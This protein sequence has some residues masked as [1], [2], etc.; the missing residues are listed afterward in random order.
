[1][2][3]KAFTSDLRVVAPQRL[4]SITTSRPMLEKVDAKDDTS[5]QK[6]QVAKLDYDDYDDYEEPKTAGQKISFYTV[7]FF[8]LSLLAAGV[9]CIF[10]TGRELFP[11]RMGPQSLFSEAFETLQ[12]RD[13][14]RILCDITY[15]T[16]FYSF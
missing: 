14:V 1:M 9:V 2:R 7:L 5:Q 11:G 16:L 10:F 15:F 12:I 3:Y 6:N 13:E 8:R 4:R